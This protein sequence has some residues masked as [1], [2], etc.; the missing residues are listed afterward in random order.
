M[1]ETETRTGV[2]VADLRIDEVSSAFPSS[3]ENEFIEQSVNELTRFME[4]CPT[5][6][7]DTSRWAKETIVF[8]GLAI[9]EARSTPVTERTE[10]EHDD[11]VSV[12]V[13]DVA[14]ASGPDG[15][16]DQ[17]DAVGMG[18]IRVSPYTFI[19]V[20]GSRHGWRV[21]TCRDLAPVHEDV[22]N[23]LHSSIWEARNIG[24]VK[25]TDL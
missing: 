22:F 24:E 23:F 13:R 2:T 10:G 9:V 20:A 25:Y 11:G 21:E 5:S 7:L 3:Y 4:E 12:L 15:I 18:N 14:R 19:L 8:S 16:E 1:S 17:I 6:W